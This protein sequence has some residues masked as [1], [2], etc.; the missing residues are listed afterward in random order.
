MDKPKEENII[1]IDVEKE[2]WEE[3]KKAASESNWIPHHIY[4]MNDWVSDV[5]KFL[6]EGKD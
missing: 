6:R 1:E 3:I 2:A 4:F 5:C